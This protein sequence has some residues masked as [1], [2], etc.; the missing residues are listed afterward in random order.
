MLIASIIFVLS[1]AAMIQFAVL[2]WR[3]GL[4]SVA[5]QPLAFES[6]LLAD[7]SRKALNTGSFH[8]VRDYQKLCPNFRQ[9]GV[10]GPGL[11]TVGAYF[12]ILQ[13]ATHFGS[14]ASS[15]AQNEMA[16]CTRYA[17]VQLS[18][19]LARTQVLATEMGSY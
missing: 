15:W 11:R 5:S 1:F 13:A 8:A 2:S 12:R 19:R 9:E 16:T 18:Q 4:L 17:A 7:L 3:A 10:A 14:V 6:D